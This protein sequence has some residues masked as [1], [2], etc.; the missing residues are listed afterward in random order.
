MGCVC[1]CGIR[2][3]RPQKHNRKAVLMLDEEKKGCFGPFGSLMYCF[4]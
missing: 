3:T 2:A 4:R 1:V